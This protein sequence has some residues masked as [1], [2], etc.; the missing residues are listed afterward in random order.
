MPHDLVHEQTAIAREQG[1]IVSAARGERGIRGVR[2]I[3]NVKPEQTEMPRQLPEMAVRDKLRDAPLLQ[4]LAG[5]CGRITH[6]MDIDD[7]IHSQ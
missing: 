5:R 3:D 1:A 2:S 4:S 7:G 6:T